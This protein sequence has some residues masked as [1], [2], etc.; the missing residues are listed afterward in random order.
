MTMASSIGSFRDRIELTEQDHRDILFDHNEFEAEF[1]DG[2]RLE[3][4]D[5]ND[6]SDQDEDEVQL[7]SYD[8]R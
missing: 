7:P 1:A 5:D 4:D 6:L 8:R 3:D 2:G